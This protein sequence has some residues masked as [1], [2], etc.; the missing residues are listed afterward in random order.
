V[1]ELILH[2]AGGGEA[3]RNA[4]GNRVAVVKAALPHLSVFEF[5]IDGP[6]DGPDPHTHDDETDSFYV[7]EGEVDFFVGGEWVSKGPGTFVSAPPGVEHGFTKRGAGR[8]R[9]LNI[10]SPGGFEHDLREMSI[11]H[12]A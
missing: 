3:L 2:H 12:A 9:F 11:T 1:D 4:Q 8:A 7:L 5:T 6:F 10:H